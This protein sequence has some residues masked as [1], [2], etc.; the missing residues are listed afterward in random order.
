MT[1]ALLGMIN[2]PKPNGK[3]STNRFYQMHGTIASNELVEM[4]ANI[5]SYPNH[6]QRRETRVMIIDYLTMAD[7]VKPLEVGEQVPNRGI[8]DKAFKQWGGTDAAEALN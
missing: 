2:M 8:L 6:S 4:I 1:G 3:D 7:P 5:D